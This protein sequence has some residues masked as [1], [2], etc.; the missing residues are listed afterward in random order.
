MLSQNEL[1]LELY[2]RRQARKSFRQYVK[3][4]SPE[5][6]WS[7][8]SERVCDELDS[9]VEAVLQGRRPILILQAP[10]QHG[11][12]ELV[13]R[14]FPAYLLGRFPDIHIGTASYA[15]DLAESMARDVKRN[16]IDDAHARV[17]PC[18]GEKLPKYSIDRISE[19][20]N[21]GGSGTYFGVGIGG[22]MTGRPIDV[23]IIDDPIKNAKEALSETVKKA[24]WE[25]KTSV[26]DTR[27]SKNSGQIIMATRWAQDDLSGMTIERNSDSERL[28]VLNF[29]AI[30]EEGEVGFD[31]SLPKGA[32]VPALHPIEQ[33]KEIKAASSEYWWAAQY[34][35]SPKAAGGNIFKDSGIHYYLPNDLPKKFDK[36]IASWDCTFKDTDGSDFVVGQ[37]W[38]KKEA[39]S[40]LLDQV[41]ARMSFT[42]TVKAVVALKQKWPRCREILI[43]DKA[44]GPAVIDTLKMSVPGLLP[45]E[46]DG[47]KLARA[48][49]VTGYWEAGNVWIPEKSIAPWITEFVSEVTTF[50]AASNDDQ[51]DALTQALRRLYPAFDRLRITQAVLDKAMGRHPSQI[52]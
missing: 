49:A 29:P 19:F 14:K 23:G 24:M 7:L 3:Y 50:P 42:E 52:R 51:V 21:P 26:F 34:Q 30:N 33:L 41:R 46:P 15:T 36:I 13:S 48:H 25:W 39:N 37:I 8:F 40:Y 10:P 2:G 16:I 27:P 6:I 17:F 22:G 4:T 20:S 35:G 5:F 9:F 45:I 38:G 31:P 43:E 32:L 28:R 18:S 12:S 1:L 47:S 44:N 11:K